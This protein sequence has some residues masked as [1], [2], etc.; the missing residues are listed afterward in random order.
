MNA[1]S[2]LI[3]LILLCI[4][5]NSG[6][7]RMCG[8][9]KVLIVWQAIVLLSIVGFQFMYQQ[10]SG[11]EK[12]KTFWAS[13]TGYQHAILY[14]IGFHRFNVPNWEAFLPYVILFSFSVGLLQLFKTQ[15]KDEKYEIDLDKIEDKYN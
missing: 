2:L 10:L 15:V 14:W 4:Y 3:V 1:T 9:W 13:W 5:L 6:L 12:F 11:I 7:E 8:Y